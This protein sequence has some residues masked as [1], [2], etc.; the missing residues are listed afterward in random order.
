[1]RL[2]YLIF[3]IKKLDNYHEI[4]EKK[5]FIQAIIQTEKKYNITIYDGE[6]SRSSQLVLTF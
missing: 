4:V 3:F 5:E 6:L 2:F 1:M